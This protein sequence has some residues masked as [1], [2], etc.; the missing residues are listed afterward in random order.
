MTI[1]GHIP[2]ALC[3]SSGKNMAAFKGNGYSFEIADYYDLSRYK[4]SMWISHSRFPTNSP[5]WWGGAHPISLL[6]WGVCH[7]GEITSYGV[8]KKFVEMAGYKCSLLTDTEVVT[9]EWDLMV[10]KHCLPIEVAAFA[11]APKYH[12]DIERMDDSSKKLAKQVRITY[13]E[14][15]LNGP[16]SI[17]VGRSRPTP[18][19]IALTD[20]KKLRPMLLGENKDNGMIYAASEECAIRVLDKDAVTWVPDAGS[21]MIAQVGKGVVR[22][23]TEQTFKGV[24]I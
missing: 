9:Y 5:G 4:G 13:K 12:S 7:N 3:I 18:T 2:G 24:L 20:R 11:M 21:P 17:I 14:A 1:N 15:L 22:R 19:M 10:R 8:N 23:G 16:F 6:D